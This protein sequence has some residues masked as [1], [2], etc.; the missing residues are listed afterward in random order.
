MRTG[1]TESPQIDGRSRENMGIGFLWV[2]NRGDFVGLLIMPLSFPILSA[3]HSFSPDLDG[4]FVLIDDRREDC[5]VNL[6][7]VI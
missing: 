6:L 5:L 1:F 2:A 3:V 4:S 7:F